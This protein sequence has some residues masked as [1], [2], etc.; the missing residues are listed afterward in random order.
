MKQTVSFVYINHNIYN[1]S[2]P[3][4]IAPTISGHINITHCP[5]FLNVTCYN[6]AQTAPIPPLSLNDT[7][8]STNTLWAILLLLHASHTCAHTPCYVTTIF[9]LKGLKSTQRQIIKFSVLSDAVNNLPNPTQV[10]KSLTLLTHLPY[11]FTFHTL[12]TQKR[13]LHDVNFPWNTFA[14]S[15]WG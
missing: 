8:H 6:F 3:S 13:V 1:D 2:S 5:F 7:R 12:M 14:S 9:R 11:F 10:S 4:L 15:C